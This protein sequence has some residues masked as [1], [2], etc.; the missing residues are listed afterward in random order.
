M[1]QASVCGAYGLDGSRPAPALWTGEPCQ[2]LTKAAEML[3]SD[4]P[5]LCRG[6]PRKTD[7]DRCAGRK[8]R[9]RLQLD[10][11]S[12]MRQ[13]RSR[14]VSLSALLQHPNAP[15]RLPIIAVGRLSGQRQFIR[16]IG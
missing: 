6:F 11:P 7:E 2:S 9:D 15:I 14:W 4:S 3:G 10:G 16:L 13:I 12:K 5:K 1:S 8:L